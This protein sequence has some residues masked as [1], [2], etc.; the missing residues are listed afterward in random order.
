LFIRETNEHIATWEGHK[1]TK[2]EALV[3]S[4]IQNIQWT[5]SF[6]NVFNTLMALSEEVYLNTNEHLRADTNVET[7]DARFIKSCKEKYPL[8]HY[9]RA[10]PLMHRLRAIKEPEEINQMQIACDITEK[11]FR[12]ILNFVKPGVKEYEV[13]AEFIHEFLMKR[14]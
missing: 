4:G 12:R 11:G 14:S 6:E 5:T 3:A 13:E 10:A 7:R 9:H 1:Y 2:E 8:H